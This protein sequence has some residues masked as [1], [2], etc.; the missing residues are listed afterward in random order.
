MAPHEFERG[1][2]TMADHSAHGGA[3]SHS[4]DAHKAT[5]EGFL[6]GAVALTLVC[7]YV[8]VALVVFRF[9][10]TFLPFW[11][12]SEIGRINSRTVR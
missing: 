10:G 11:R 12:A 7:F 2:P 6:T 1:F 8:L 4:F 3:S 9:G 5:Y